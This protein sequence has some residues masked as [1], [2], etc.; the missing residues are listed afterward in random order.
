METTHL[1]QWF[2]IP[3]K[4]PANLCGTGGEDGASDS[5]GEDAP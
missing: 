5:P 2:N 1:Q 4:T 3:A